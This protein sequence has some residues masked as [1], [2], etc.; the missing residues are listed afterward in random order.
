M[1]CFRFG[2]EG[3]EGFSID[4]RPDLETKP[5]EHIYQ[6][7]LLVREAD[8]ERLR[9]ALRKLIEDQENTVMTLGEDE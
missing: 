7:Q 8:I 4:L 9:N 3:P 6:V 1:N 2:S 5:Y